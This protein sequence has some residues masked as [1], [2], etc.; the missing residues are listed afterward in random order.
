MFSRDLIRYIEST[1]KEHN[2]ELPTRTMVNVMKD[3]TTMATSDKFIKVGNSIWNV[4]V[5]RGG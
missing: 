4:F 1:F 3:D 5:G 2:I